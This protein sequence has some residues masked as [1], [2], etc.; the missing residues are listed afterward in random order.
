MITT[1]PFCG[2][3]WIALIRWLAPARMVSVRECGDR[4]TV[5]MALLLRAGRRVFDGL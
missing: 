4:N 5:A 1:L 2:R 3:F